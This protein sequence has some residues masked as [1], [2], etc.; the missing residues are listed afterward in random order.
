MTG[1]AVRGKGDWNKIERK[2]ALLPYG[3]TTARQSS[4]QIGRAKATT[5]PICGA[6]M[7]AV[8]KPTG[9][10]GRR[11]RRGRRRQQRR[12]LIDRCSSAAFGLSESQ[13]PADGLDFMS[14][15]TSVLFGHYRLY[16]CE[17]A[18]LL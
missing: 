3:L 13:C 9:D 4:A 17:I 7:T 16:L 5:E 1:Q 11:N 15:M 8:E 6:T 18:V 14:L 12:R 2:H 10:A